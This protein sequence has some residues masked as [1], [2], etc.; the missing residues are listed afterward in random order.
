[1]N[2]AL[3]SHPMRGFLRKDG[4]KG[5]RNVV[6]VAY[7]VEC[8]HHVSRLIVQKSAADDV[9]LIGSARVESRDDRV[10]VSDEVHSSLGVLL[11]VIELE[12]PRVVLTAE[13]LHIVE[14]EHSKDSVVIGSGGL[15]HEAFRRLFRLLPFRLDH[16]RRAAGGETREEEK[17][18]RSSHGAA[19]FLRYF[20]MPP[21]AA[22]REFGPSAA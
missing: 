16:G 6:A 12:G 19:Y 10:H 21:P 8:A 5:I 3:P 15:Q 14:H 1:M 22:S 2:A 9:H 13:T 17:P 20:V 7:L 11:L 4:R 18:N